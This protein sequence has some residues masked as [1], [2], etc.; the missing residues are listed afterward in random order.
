[1][2]Y[3]LFEQLYEQHSDT[4]YQ[5]IFFLVNNKELAED[6]TQEVFFRAYKRLD[7]FAGQSTLYTWLRKIARNLVYDHYRR[8]RMIQFVPFVSNDVWQDDQLL[9]NEIF[10]KGE[11]LITLYKAITYLK[12]AYREVLILRK[13]E[14][15]SIKETAMVLGCTEAKVKNNTTRAIQSLKKIMKE[16]EDE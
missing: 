15:L 3:K 6:L 1:M 11:E 7:T 9:P 14:G 16:K 5:Y 4:I 2:R 8:K 12:L 13:I 10:E